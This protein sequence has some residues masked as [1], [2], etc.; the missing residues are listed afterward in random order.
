MQGGLQVTVDFIEVSGSTSLIY[1]RFNS[2]QLAVKVRGLSDHRIG[3]K[4]E[5]K[6]DIHRALVFD[7]DGHLVPSASPGPTDG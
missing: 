6:I 1:A 2:Q 7:A 4:I 3:D 5:V